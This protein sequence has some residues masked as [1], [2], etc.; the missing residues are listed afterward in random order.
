MRFLYITS[1]VLLIC[2]CSREGSVV[3]SPNF[4]DLGSVEISQSESFSIEL[5]N[6]SEEIL[7]KVWISSSCD[8]DYLGE[9]GDR[10]FPNEKKIIPAKYKAN[11][12]L[13]VFRDFV[14]VNMKIGEAYKKKKIAIIGEKVKNVF[15]YPNKMDIEVKRGIGNVFQILQISFLN[16]SSW[17]EVNV[18]SSEMI[19]RFN[20]K[21][22]VIGCAGISN[23][24][25][26]IVGLIRI[27]RSHDFDNKVRKGYLIIDAKDNSDKQYRFRLPYIV[28]QQ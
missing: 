3:V 8:C 26:D 7:D 5:C 22:G 6:D 18:N 4:V 13:G 12:A 17:K 14:F 16:L 2:G 24:G 10:I 19:R 23:N 9:Y 25:K 1:V 28:S 21:N 27:S 11:N 15:I 20:I